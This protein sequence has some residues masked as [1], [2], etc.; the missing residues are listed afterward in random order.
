MDEWSEAQIRYVADLVPAGARGWGCSVGGGWV[1]VS[2]S[3]PSVRSH[4]TDGSPVPPTRLRLL[5]LF[6]VTPLMT[7]THEP[8]WSQEGL[9]CL[10]G[11]A[12]PLLPSHGILLASPPASPPLGILVFNEGFNNSLP[13]IDRR[14]FISVGF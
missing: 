14:L 11:P 6:N 5:M 8:G 9:W 3:S 4:Q 12:M 10:W 7:I 1:W 2:P 13:L